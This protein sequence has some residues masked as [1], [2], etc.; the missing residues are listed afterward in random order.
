LPECGE[1]FAWG[2][3][4][5]HATTF[6]QTTVEP[7]KITGLRNV[8]NLY[9]TSHSTYSVVQTV[10]GEL[11]AWGISNEELP[12]NRNG[13]PQLLKNIEGVMNVICTE[14]SV[15]FLVQR[16]KSYTIVNREKFSDITFSLW[17]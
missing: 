17:H 16:K 1:V 5:S 7:Q 3:V 12:I 9:T 14:R 10:H 11:F 13:E 6:S 8:M 4:N 2:L 15:Y